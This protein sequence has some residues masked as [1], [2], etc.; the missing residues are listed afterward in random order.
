MYSANLAN[1]YNIIRVGKLV[2]AA[3]ELHGETAASVVAT[4]GELGFA[5]VSELRDRVLQGD[6]SKSAS[7]IDNIIDALLEDRFLTYLRKAHFS[8]HHDVQRTVELS[9]LSPV[10]I[11]K[12]SGT[13]A[14]MEF[15]ANVERGVTDLTHTSKPEFGY[16]NEEWGEDVPKAVTANGEVRAFSRQREALVNGGQNKTSRAEMCQPNYHKVV[17]LAQ[18][19]VVSDVAKKLHGKKAAT[20][21]KCVVRQVADGDVWSRLPRSHL[22]NLSV[23]ALLDDYNAE[24][25]RKEQGD[26]PR[27]NGVNGKVGG[28][29]H[30][31]A[32]EMTLGD[33]NHELLF[34]TEDTLPFLEG[35]PGMWTVQKG[36]FDDWL[37]RE[38][39]LRVMDSRLE[40]P[41]PR[42]L[43]ILMDKGKLEE[44]ILQEIGLLGA[45][46][47]RQSLSILKQ[48]G[49]LD[50]Q[51][52]PRN[53]Q[54]MPNQ[55]V[56]LWS[57]E[58]GRVHNLVLE[59]I[60]AGIAKMIELLKLERE[61]IASTLAKIERE[62]V[63][64]RE[65]EMLAEAEFLILQR[66]RRL[67]AWIWGEI[68]RMDATVAILRDT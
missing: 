43:R 13:K 49:Y 19:A 20:I 15:A 25:E 51:E 28:Y 64:G 7:S 17:A 62:D 4:A 61:K 29:T 31:H 8:E 67:E 63:K 66:F 35:S 22:H 2:E 6:H 53:P 40:Q 38:E 36:A 12:L 10:E 44:R 37:R 32:D 54:R 50:L 26:R 60:Y 16:V 1:A 65:G 5:T 55:T 41:A 57:H 9:L 59:H 21:M 47:L 11:A 58:A 52:V 34:L 48:I 42:I 14:K 33:L 30:P 45:K 56:F 46:E 18:S 27:T 39:T 23:S 3:R 24:M 68:H